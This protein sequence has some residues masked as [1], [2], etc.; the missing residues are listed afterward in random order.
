MKPTAISLEEYEAA[1][2][3]L[4]LRHARRIWLVHACVFAV[5]AALLAIVEVAANGG[6]WW[7]YVLLLS[8]ALALFAQYRWSIRYGDAHAREQQIR[9][10][11]RAGRSKE[12]L[13]P[14]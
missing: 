2:R 4:A 10:E 11:W 8:W 1:E 9:V 7:P 6:I 12:E 13:V 5:A 14:R 3:E